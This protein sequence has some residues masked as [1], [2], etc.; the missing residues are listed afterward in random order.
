[1]LNGLIWPLLAL[2]AHSA[3][4]DKAPQAIL[5]NLPSQ[6]VNNGRLGAVAS[7]NGVCS[8]IGIDLLK[9]GGNAADAV[10]LSV[11]L[12]YNHTDMITSSLARCSALA[13]LV[14]NPFTA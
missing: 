13:L 4:A 12:K 14:S 1:M 10:W 5:D 9:A 11:W 6:Q 8:Q 3:F 2:Y 7:E